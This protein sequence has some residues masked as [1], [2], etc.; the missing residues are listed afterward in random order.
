MISSSRWSVRGAGRLVAGLLGV[1][2]CAPDPQDLDLSSLKGMV[3]VPGGTFLR[4]CTAQALPEHDVS[5]PWDS[6]EDS[7]RAKCDTTYSPSSSVELDDYYID[8][9]EVTV[10]AYRLFVAENPGREQAYEDSCNWENEDDL[11]MNCVSWS[12]ARAYC[13]WR[14]KRLPTEAE[15]EKAA[16][17]A[18][19]RLWPWGNKVACSLEEE[20]GGLPCWSRPVAS[21]PR[22]SSIYGSMDM[23]GSVAEWV[24]DWYVSNHDTRLLDNPTGPA[25][26]A[27][28]ERVFRGSAYGDCLEGDY[29]ALFVRRGEN[30]ADFGRAPSTGFRCALPLGS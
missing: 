6:D 21:Q 25:E 5:C 20:L 4:G 8:Q 24:N 2:A 12:D 7:M 14:G 27:L 28:G 11:P 26:S 10:G 9:T 19:G 15:W 16:R 1:V 3:Y 22:D 30:P 13:E 18:S 17:G 29:S 23:W